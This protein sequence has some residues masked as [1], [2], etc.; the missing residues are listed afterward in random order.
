MGP[1]TRVT[2]DFSAMR[3]TRE[4]G[5]ALEENIRVN[6]E[7]YT[8][9]ILFHTQASRG[10]LLDIEEGKHSSATGSPQGMLR[11]RP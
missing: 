11:E 2:A 4:K 10:T 5:R 6:L 8:L 7:F 3:I 9:R 1:N